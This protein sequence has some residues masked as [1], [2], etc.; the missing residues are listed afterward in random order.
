[1]A[2][3]HRTTYGQQ[4]IDTRRLNRVKEN[5][6]K[7]LFVQNIMLKIIAF[8][9][10]IALWFLVVGEKKA[11]MSFWIP[12]EFRNLPKDVVITGEPVQE[13]EVRILGSKKVLKSF[14]P[15][16]LTASI[17]LSNAKPGLNNLR[18]TH[19]DIKT[20]KGIEIININ[21]SSVL[22]HMEAFSERPESGSQ[23]LENKK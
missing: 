23:N 19:N 21:P 1:M 13:I 5:L 12:L 14:S 22:I 11:E 9:F 10:A 20:P 4:P 3:I 8:A 7:G 17:D 2:P 6:L 16:K 18:I 15:D